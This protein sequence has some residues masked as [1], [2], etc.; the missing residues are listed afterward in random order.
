MILLWGVADDR[1][2]AAVQ[3]ALA[4]RGAPVFHLDQRLTDLTAIELSLDEDGLVGGIDTGSDRC[5]LE[6]VASVYV[7]P[8]DTRA[9]LDAAAGEALVTHAERVDAAMQAFLDATP[10][11]LVNPAAAMASNGSKPYQTA[12]IARHGFRI[13]D[14]LVTTDPA[15]VA[16]FRARHGAIIYKSV[17]GVRSIVSRLTDDDG[18]RL[19]DIAWCPTQFQEHVP[20]R[21]TRVHVVGDRL[22]AC[23]IAADADDYRYAHRQDEAI[24]VTE[25]RLPDAIASRCRA[26]AAALGL[27]L[28]G[29]DLRRT[30]DGEWY[31]F[32]VNPSPAFTFYEDLT[33]L[34]I[35]DA[36][37]DL[38]MS[39]P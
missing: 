11:L 22:F 25:A 36:V 31:C 18:E 12:L 33:G 30:P 3:A 4:R 2:L 17:S 34:P 37:A 20:G 39:R 14:T 21:D 29:I 8:F 19:A 28:A 32:E 13:P 26:L 5:A 6:E 9:L 15:E 27:P 7:R 23:E 35:A 16:G 1:P 24:R 38:L 10:A